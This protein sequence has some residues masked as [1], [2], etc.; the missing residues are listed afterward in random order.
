M[1]RGIKITELD[2]YSSA[3][4]TD[5]LAIVNLA[6]NTTMKITASELL[7]GVDHTKILNRGTITHL[8]IDAHIAGALTRTEWDQNGFENKT[9]STMSFTDGTLTFSIQP[10]V[11]SFDYWVAGVKYTSTGDTIAISNTEGI[12]VIYYDGDTISEAVNPSAGDTG[13]VIRT[14]AIVSILYW[15]LSEATLIYFGEERHGKNMSPETHAYLHFLEG[16]RYLSGLALLD[17]SVDGGGATEDAQFGIDAGSVS[18]EDL[19]Q[20]ISTVASTTGLPIYYML[21]ASAEWQKHTEAGFSVRTF[22]GTTATRLAWNEYTGGAW[23]LTQATNNDFVLCHVFATTEKDKPMIAIMGQDEYSTK[24][25]ARAGALVEVKSLILNDV[26]FPEIRPI[27]TIIFQTNTGM[28][29]AVNAKVVST[30]DG[31]DYIDWRSETIDR[32]SISTSDHEALANIGTY[33]HPEIDTHIDD[34]TI[35]FTEASISHLNITNI[36]TNTHAQIDTAI[37]ASTN[38]IADVTTNPHGVT[39]TQVGSATDRKSVV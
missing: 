5:P 25:L 16:L 33:T 23:Q 4:P 29:S 20:A 6:T 37:T 31:D 14:K 9:D 36:G 34:T 24:K 10:T 39:H 18:D 21:G 7:A 17:M 1:A 38:H 15:D 22:D 32:V 19:Y 27:A 2:P 28:A 11:T 12:H 13:Q 35:H 30:D 26:L 3:Q 8:N